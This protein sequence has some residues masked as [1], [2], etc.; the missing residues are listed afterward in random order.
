MENQLNNQA[1]V[2]GNYNEIPTT[3]TSNVTLVTMIEGLTVTIA[4]DKVTWADGA[5]TYTIT[6][7]NQT[8]QTYT[9]P[10]ITDVLN[11]TLVNFT[12]GSVEVNGTKLDET[13]YTY[14]QETGTL[15]INLED[16][17]KSTSNKIT[18]QVTKKD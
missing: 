6:I 1:T 11:T 15:T 2:V 18:F 4:A 17:E 12:A 14:N 9:T 3:I 8:E 7:D 16:I 10:I 13:K 5:L